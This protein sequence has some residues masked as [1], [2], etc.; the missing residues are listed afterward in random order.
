MHLKNL[1]H[2]SGASWQAVHF[3]IGG[4]LYVGMWVVLARFWGGELFGEF[5]YL[6]AYAAFWG[7]FFDFGLDVII[8]RVVAGGK[9]RVPVELARIKAAVVFLGALTALGLGTVLVR[10]NLVIVAVLL[11]GVALFSCANF[12]NGYLRGIERL[13]IEAKIG[14][15]QK[16]LFVA[17]VLAGVA[18][19][20]GMLWVACS[21]TGSQALAL[22]LTAHY[23]LRKGFIIR[24][25]EIDRLRPRLR[26]ALWLWGVTLMMFL[27]LRLDLFLIKH[28]ADAATLGAYSAGFRI[29]EG[30]SLLGLA[31]MNA[32]F[33][34]LARA[35]SSGGGMD[36]LVRSGGLLLLAG[37]ALLAAVNA[38]AAPLVVN[39]LFGAGFEAA[40]PVLR[41]LGYVLPVVYLSMLFGQSF[42]AMA[43]PGVYFFALMVAVCIGALADAAAIPTYGEMGAVIGFGAR[44]ICALALLLF[45]WSRSH[46]RDRRQG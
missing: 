19:G 42:M 7:I 12:I 26:E 17:A 14:L 8:T 37:G 46:R 34:R 30:F 31:F 28:L 24:S 32:F 23:G 6:Y 18:K 36:G 44:E 35:H 20:G 2:W 33:P 11:F 41:Y 45:L 3:S 10:G 38:I 29:V 13:D 5:N 1:L 15:A 21:Y 27:S 9:Q 22:V 4:A 16:A 43:R 40:M 39:V 25:D